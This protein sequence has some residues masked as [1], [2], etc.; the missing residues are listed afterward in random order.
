M[1]RFGLIGNPISASKSPL[2]FRAG[3][4]EKYA[5]DLIE[6]A[7]FGTAYRRFLDGYDGINVT[8]PFKL[9]AFAKADSKSETCT[10]I[11]AANLLIKTDSGTRAYNTDFCG[12]ILSILDAIM[13]EGGVGYFNLYGSDYSTVKTILPSFYGHRPKA[14]IAGC[15]GAGRAAAAAAAEMGYETVLVNRSGSKALDIAKDMPCYDFSVAPLR[16]FP[17]LFRECDLIIYTIPGKIPELDS[18]SLDM[19]NGS[20][21]IILEAN[22]SNPSF[23]QKDAETLNSGGCRYVSGRRWLLYQALAGFRIFTGENPDFARMCQVL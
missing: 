14:M 11:G 18:I 9:Q 8:A 23:S 15:G 7:D 16:D 6:E 21:K 20:G 10:R 4:K 13:P 17:D 3:Y 22:Y 5:Y 12:V 19:Y 1:K 2:L